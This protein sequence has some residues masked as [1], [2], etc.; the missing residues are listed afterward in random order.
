VLQHHFLQSDSH[1]HPI[2]NKIILFPSL[3]SIFNLPVHSWTFYTQHRFIP[4]PSLAGNAKF[5]GLGAGLGNTERG[6]QGLADSSTIKATSIHV[7]DFGYLHFISCFYR[8]YGW[9]F[10]EKHFFFLALVL[11][12]IF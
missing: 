9:N 3:Y 12:F 10:E 4:K 7:Q 2:Q 6:K 5:R 11:L 1:Q 8:W